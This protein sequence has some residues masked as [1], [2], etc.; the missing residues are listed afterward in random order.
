VEVKSVNAVEQADRKNKSLMYGAFVDP[1]YI[2][3]KD[4]NNTS[5][6]YWIESSAGSKDTEY[7]AMYSIYYDE[8]K[9]TNPDY[10][11]KSGGKPY[12]WRGDTKQGDYFSGGFFWGSHVIPNTNGQ[13]KYSKDTLN[14][15]CQWV[16]PDGIHGNI[17]TVPPKKISKKKQDKNLSVIYG[18]LFGGMFSQSQDFTASTDRYTTKVSA[19]GSS[20]FGFNIGYRIN[21]WIGFETGLQKFTSGQ[22]MEV[23]QTPTTYTNNKVNLMDII[24]VPL[25]YTPRFNIGQ[26]INMYP[27]IG[28]KLLFNSAD[29]NTSA[30]LNSTDQSGSLNLN[31]ENSIG[32][33]PMVSFETGLSAEYILSRQLA[34]LLKANFNSLLGENVKSIF[35]DTNNVTLGSLINKLEGFNGLLGLRFYLPRF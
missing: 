18:E 13:I 29:K 34:V 22:D 2:D 31:I 30:K 19:Y 8:S 11:S 17:I 14:F 7:S 27:S 10:L 12:T 21:D 26:N 16:E 28:I 23:T 20:T 4:D 15:L 3:M 25:R 33:S 9:F 1:D 5:V 6:F 24:S 32:N 35:S